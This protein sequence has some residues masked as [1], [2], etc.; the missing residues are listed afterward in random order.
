M[1]NLHNT[2][3]RVGYNYILTSIALSWHSVWCVLVCQT[4]HLHIS[5][6]LISGWVYD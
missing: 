3:H 5:E 6:H 2:L 1:H 4:E